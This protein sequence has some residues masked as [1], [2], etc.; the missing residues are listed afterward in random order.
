MDVQLNIQK[1]RNANDNDSAGEPYRIH[2]F[3]KVNIYAD[4]LIGADKDSLKSI[5]HENYTIYY[6]NML[7]YKPKALDGCHFL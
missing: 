7:K 2:R 5:E 3:K 4:Y 6:N 1:P